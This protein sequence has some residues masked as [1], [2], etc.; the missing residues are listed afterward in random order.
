M[1]FLRLAKAAW[2]CPNLLQGGDTCFLPSVR[3]L[4]GGLLTGD[5]CGLPP[6]L[7]QASGISFEYPFAEWLHPSFCVKLLTRVFDESCNTIYAS[8]M[9]LPCFCGCLAAVATLR[10]LCSWLL[11]VLRVWWAGTPRELKM[12]QSIGKQEVLGS[13]AGELTAGTGFY[14]LAHG[15]ILL[16]IIASDDFR[17]GYS[18]LWVRAEPVPQLAISIRKL[19]AVPGE[20][21]AWGSD[22]AGEWNQAW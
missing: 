22:H 5:T 14:S 15:S 11:N 9:F 8:H 17:L 19:H 1:T 21:D 18:P 6:S 20:A 3:Q 16:V 2:S 13:G 4:L 7:F 10:Y 12:L